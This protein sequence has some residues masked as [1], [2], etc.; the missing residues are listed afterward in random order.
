LDTHLNQIGCDNGEGNH[1]PGEIDFSK[2][3][4]IGIE[5]VRAFAEAILKIVPTY[6]TG[7]IEDSL[8]YAVGRNAGN[9]TKHKHKHDG[10]ENGLNNEP[11]WTKN[12]LLIECNDVTLYIHR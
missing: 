7:K 2:D 8:W 3:G 11:H 10:C 12:G 1:Q 5:C 6:E 9:A 4:L